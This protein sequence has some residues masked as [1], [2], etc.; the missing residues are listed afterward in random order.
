MNKIKG[1]SWFS[2][3]QLI[4]IDK[5]AFN[6]SAVLPFK[7]FKH[8]VYLSESIFFLQFL[9]NTFF[10]PFLTPTLIFINTFFFLSCNICPGFPVS[11]FTT[12]QSIGSQ[13][14]RNSIKN[15]LSNSSFA[16]NPSSPNCCNRSS[17]GSI[18]ESSRSSS[19]P[20]LH[21]RTLS[22]CHLKIIFSSLEGFERLICGI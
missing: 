1:V 9:V 19:F 2:R 7:H 22:L 6:Q 15:S 20:I 5:N 16:T 17:P 4:L 14:S 11:D 3:F 8:T 12:T 13:G 10:L 18:K 21:I